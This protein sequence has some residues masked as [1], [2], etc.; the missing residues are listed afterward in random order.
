MSPI[1]GKPVRAA[2]VKQVFRA[3]AGWKFTGQ[4]DASYGRVLPQ[5]PMPSKPSWAITGTLTENGR[6]MTFRSD[7]HAYTSAGDR[8][9]IQYVLHVQHDGSQVSAGV[10]D[11]G[12][13]QIGNGQPIKLKGLAG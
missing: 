11:D 7:L 1:P 9:C 12:R 13:A 6:T 5:D 4:V 3:P 10:Y 2:N 8:G